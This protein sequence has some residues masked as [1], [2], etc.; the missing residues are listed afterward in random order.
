[1]ARIL[2]AEDDCRVSSFLERGLRA[3]GFSTVV[4]DDGERAQALGRTDDFD[5]LILDLGLPEKE[6]LCVLQE[7]RSRGKMLPVLV[8]TGRR[9]RDAATCLN[10]GADDYMTNLAAD[11][12][13]RSAYGLDGQP[14]AR[15]EPATPTA[16]RPVN[17]DDPHAGWRTAFAVVLLTDIVD[18][19]PEKSPSGTGPG[20]S[21]ATAT[22]VQPTSRSPDVVDTSSGTPVPVRWPPSPSR[23]RRSS[24]PS[25]SS[26]R[27]PRGTCRCAPACT[28]ASSRHWT[29]GTS[30]G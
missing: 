22:T 19:R 23:G 15:Q 8:L 9:D 4:A 16:R 18:S 7:L 10:Q 3:S 21:C 30:A 5:L 11:T 6:G 20:G 25:I 29:T 12:P 1:M 27:W 17:G 26:P 24:Q 2:I 13:A 28:P 14:E